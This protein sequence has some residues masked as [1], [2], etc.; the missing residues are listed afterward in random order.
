MYLLLLRCARRMLGPR[1]QNGRGSRRDP[2][3]GQATGKRQHKPFVITKEID[4]SSP[5]LYA[6]LV[7][8]EPITDWVLQFWAAKTT[9]TVAGAAGVETMRCSVRLT[10]AGLCDIRFH[11]LNNK[12]PDL[13]RYAEYEEVAFVY[14]SIEWTWVPTG[15]STSDS[16]LFR[17]AAKA[18]GASGKSA[19][20]KT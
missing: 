7:T 15:L 11:M 17:R 2:A 5:R 14:Q 13:A 3:S 12:N 10:H 9:G 8:H 19:V 16:L 20:K 6:A 4:E 1:P 18:R